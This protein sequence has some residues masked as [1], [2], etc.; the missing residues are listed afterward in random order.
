[1]RGLGC[2]LHTSKGAF[3]YIVAPSFPFTNLL[4]LFILLLSHIP[5]EDTLAHLVTL[6]PNQQ[7]S[8]QLDNCGVDFRLCNVFFRFDRGSQAGLIYSAFTDYKP[9][10]AVTLFAPLIWFHEKLR[11]ENM[12]RQGQYPKQPPLRIRCEHRKYS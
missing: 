2:F 12:G 9:F 11:G 7:V 1:M 6:N 8:W 3:S 10:L 4:S 5:V